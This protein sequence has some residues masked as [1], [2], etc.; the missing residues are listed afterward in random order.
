MCGTLQTYMPY[1]KT[2][3]FVKLNC[4]LGI[5]LI[6]SCRSLSQEVDIEL[7]QCNKTIVKEG[8]Q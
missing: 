1:H 2:S 4:T 6:L 8:L 3:I 7:N 5:L